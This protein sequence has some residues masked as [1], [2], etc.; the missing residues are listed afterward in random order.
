MKS[1]HKKNR[2]AVSLG[3]LGGSVNSPAQNEAR[4]KNGRKG[5]RPKKAKNK[6][7]TPLTRLG[8]AYK[9]DQTENNSRERLP[10]LGFKQKV[11]RQGANPGSLRRKI[12]F[13]SGR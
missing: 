4:A 2:A 5:G 7:L 9:Y 13:P 11:R 6:Q 8:I 10:G 3:R 12:H 1:Q